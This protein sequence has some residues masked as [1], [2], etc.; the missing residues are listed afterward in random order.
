MEE[1]I[2][3]DKVIHQGKGIAPTVA[4]DTDISDEEED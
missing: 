4:D 2:K 3:E 1:E